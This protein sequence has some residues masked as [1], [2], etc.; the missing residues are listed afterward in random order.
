MG[1]M[2]L[3]IKTVALFNDFLTISWTNGKNS[4]IRL[5]HLRASCPC[6]GC[7]GEHD[8]LGNTYINKQQSFLKTSFHLL[9]YE[10]VGLYGLRFFWE[11]GHHDGIYTFPFLLSLS[12]EKK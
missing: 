1:F 8:V 2:N 4:C 10:E 7:S 5:K 3:S 9:K 6:A 11:D 12:N